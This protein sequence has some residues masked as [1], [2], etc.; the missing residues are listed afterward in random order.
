MEAARQPNVS[1]W[2]QPSA[3]AIFPMWP[4]LP[5][6]QPLH[7]RRLFQPHHAGLTLPIM[8][9]HSRK[10]RARFTNAGPNGRGAA[11]EVSRAL[12]A[13]GRYPRVLRAEVADGHANEW[14]AFLAASDVGRPE[15]ARAL[16]VKSNSVQFGARR[17]GDQI[18]TPQLTL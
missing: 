3:R 18:R 7:A 10:L 15:L 13:R 2:D 6:E 17:R 16:I 5:H 4:V 1:K 11:L 8:T 14:R 12:L 9:H